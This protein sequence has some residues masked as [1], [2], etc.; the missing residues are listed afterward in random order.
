[1]SDTPV[2]KLDWAAINRSLAE[3]NQQLL[4]EYE[5]LLKGPAA[6][7]LWPSKEDEEGKTDE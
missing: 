1:M 3:R 4:R 7:A 6:Q 2:E 5:G